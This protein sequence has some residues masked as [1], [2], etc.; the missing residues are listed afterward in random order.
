ML[1]VEFLI[2]ANKQ[3]GLVLAKLWEWYVLTCLY[4]LSELWEWYVL[5]C[6]Y[7]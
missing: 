7:V 6:L 2:R 4:M 1:N 3:N 5:T